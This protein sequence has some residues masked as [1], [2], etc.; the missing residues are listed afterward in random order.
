MILNEVETFPLS[1]WSNFFEEEFNHA[2][3]NYSNSSASS[4]EKLSWGHIKHIIKDKSCLKNIVSIANTCIELGYWPNHFKKSTTI[5]IPKPNKSSYNSLKSFRP[6]VLLDTMGKLIEKIIGERL[7]FHIVSNNFIYQSQLGGLNF[8][9]TTDADIV[10]THFIHTKWIKNMSTNVLAFD[11]AQFF[12]SLNHRLLSSILN[13]AGFKSRI[14]NFFSNYLVNRKTNYSWNCFFSH[15]FD[16]NVGVGQGSALS[17]ILS[18]LYLSPFLHI[19]EKCLK[20]LNLKISTLSFVDNGLLITQNK[21]FQVSNACLF[22]SYNVASK[23]LFKFGLLV[24]HSKT[25]VFHFSR[26]HGTFNPSP[27]NLS[28]IGGPM[29]IPKDT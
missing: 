16:I 14:V 19:L 10:L 4:P 17:P 25:E 13:K 1:S 22:S 5:V 12:P 18:A 9:S 3:V 11:I 15:L 8:K 27:L 26:S 21:S 20:N 7:Q 24:E 23:L 2:I 28:S 6:I 29:L